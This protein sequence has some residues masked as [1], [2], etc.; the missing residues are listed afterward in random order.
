MTREEYNRLRGAMPHI[1][2]AIFWLRDAKDPEVCELFALL[3]RAQ[4]LGD[5]L[6]QR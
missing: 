4:M 2:D 6:Q 1:S 3:A 5:R